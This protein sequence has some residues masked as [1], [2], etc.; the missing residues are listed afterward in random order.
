MIIF[1]KDINYMLAEP[2]VHQIHTPLTILHD[3]ENEWYAVRRD[4]RT[5]VAKRFCGWDGATKFPDFNWILEGSLW[6]DILHWLIAKGVIPESEND[7]IDQE[8]AYIIRKCGGPKARGRT[9]DMLLKA[10]SK[11]VQIATGL[12][13]EKEGAVIPIYKLEYGKVERIN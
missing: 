1:Y 8:L 12:A 6:H 4:S 10:R 11:Y 3:Y 9:T 5:L 7:L 2:A 13:N